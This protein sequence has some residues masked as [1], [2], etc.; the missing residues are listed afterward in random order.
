MYICFTTGL[1]FT[2]DLGMKW[3]ISQGR[4][5][6]MHVKREGCSSEN[7]PRIT[8]RKQTI[9]HSSSPISKNHPLP[10]MGIFSVCT[11]HFYFFNTL[12]DEKN[13]V[14]RGWGGGGGYFFYKNVTSVRVAQMILFHPLMVTK[15]NFWNSSKVIP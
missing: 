6:H 13:I 3:C 11:S 5:P 9:R 1:S 14:T 10:S 15:D 2:N 8:S 7:W 4:D 12:Q